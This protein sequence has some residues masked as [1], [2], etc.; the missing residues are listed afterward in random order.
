MS[1]IFL[2]C[3]RVFLIENFAG[4]RLRRV[5]LPLAPSCWPKQSRPTLHDLLARAE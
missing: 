2:A 5:E 3:V 1:L 4:P